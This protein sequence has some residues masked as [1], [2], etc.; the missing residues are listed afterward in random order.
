MTTEQ[1][2][3]FLQAH[4]PMPDDRD[5]S[6]AL[7][8]EYDAVRQFFMD[9]PDPRCIPL[10][11]T[12]FGAGDGLGVYQ[13]VEDVMRPFSRETVVPHLQRGLAH[14]Q[15]SIRYWNAE[16]AAHFPSLDLLELLGTLL[17]EDD[18]DLQA[19]A[20]IALGQIQDARAE[21]L[22]RNALANV[23]TP[24]LAMLLQKLVS[25]TIARVS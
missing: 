1:G 9:H 2:L 18:E 14:S 24:H 20:A 19:A 8:R 17:T 11:L 25:N 4:Q 15:R 6:E 3:A 23:R 12:S 22:L 13:L 16:I 10:F 21:T 7:I 5:L